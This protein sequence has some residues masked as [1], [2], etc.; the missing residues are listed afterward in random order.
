MKFRSVVVTVNPIRFREMNANDGR[1]PGRTVGVSQVA[2]TLGIP[3]TVTVA[4]VD[5]MVNSKLAASL[6]ATEPACYTKA[7]RKLRARCRCTLD[8]GAAIES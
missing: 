6:Q 2:R 7:G 3:D 5:E 4:S 1:G 8:K